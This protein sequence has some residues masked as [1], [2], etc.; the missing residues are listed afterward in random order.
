MGLIGYSMTT[1]FYK[2]RNRLILF[3]LSESSKIVLFKG[4]INI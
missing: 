2:K 3:G 1:K 4:H